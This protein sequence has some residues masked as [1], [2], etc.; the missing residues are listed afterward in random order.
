VK[1]VKRLLEGWRMVLIP[2]KSI[3]LWEQQWHPCAIVGSLTFLYLVIWL[4]D[5]SALAT[6]AVIGLILNFVDF[7]VPVICNSLY[8]PSSWTGQKEKMFEE[9]CRSIVI[10]YNKILYQIKSFYT[11]RDTSPFMVKYI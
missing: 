8:G 10:H 6:F 7:I 1:K 4:L 11:M 5:M 2:L 3:I 9:I